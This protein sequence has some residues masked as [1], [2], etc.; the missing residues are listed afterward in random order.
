[1][2][3]SSS[4][5]ASLGHD[6]LSQDKLLACAD[7]R[8]P[9]EHSLRVGPPGSIF[10][11]YPFL[12]REAFDKVSNDELEK[13]SLASRFL[14]SSV[15]AS[16]DLVDGDSNIDCAAD[17][18]IRCQAL[19]M[20]AMIAYSEIGVSASFFSD[21]RVLFANFAHAIVLQRHFMSGRLKLGS[22]DV[23]IGQTIAIDKTSLA[24]SAVLCLN[25]LHRQS[26]ESIKALQGA[27][28]K[29]NL[30]R[31]YYDDLCDW[32]GDLRS[33]R[34]SLIVSELAELCTEDIDN[35]EW[36]MSREPA[37]KVYHNNFVN[38]IREYI[39]DLLQD[40]DVRYVTN[41]CCGF[42]FIVK[43]LGTAAENLFQDIVAIKNAKKV[44]D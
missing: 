30:A 28:D 20:E 4:L 5:A 1:M 35:S 13:L 42:A 6:S 12:F 21:I 3:S 10:G 7:R 8:W 11:F 9:L 37:L 32:R 34:P 39:F 36:R 17:V 23:K 25:D 40:K 26:P 2:T 43:S 38:R 16:D 18:V 31:Q 22:L 15:V 27:L 41:R 19:T 29:F 33:L 14:A 44:S 24:F